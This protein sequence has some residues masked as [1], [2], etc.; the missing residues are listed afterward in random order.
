MEIPTT[1]TPSF[2]RSWWSL[3]SVGIISRHGLHQVAQKSTNVARASVHSTANGRVLS[4]VEVADVP[5]VRVRVELYE[6]DRDALKDV[7]PRLAAAISDFDAAGVARSPLTAQFQGTPTGNPDAP[8][9]G[10]LGTGPTSD[11]DVQNVL[12]FLDGTFADEVQLSTGRL[13]LSATLRFLESE[14]LARSLSRPSLT[15]LSGE[16]AQ[17]LVGGEIPIRQNAVSEASGGVITTSVV[18]EEFGIGLAVRPL[19]GRDGR[20]TLDL[21]PEITEPDFDLTADVVAATG[22]AQETIGFRTRTL[23]TSARLDD[24]QALLV[25]GLQTRSHEGT[26]SGLPVLGDAPIIGWL[27]RETAEQQ[28]R[29]ELVLV[30]TPVVLREPEARALLWHHGAPLDALLDTLPPPPEPEPEGGAADAATAPE[31]TPAVEAGS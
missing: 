31:D 6:V 14:G 3:E 19:V 18:T 5:Q 25:G 26:K 30:V 22:S 4:F 16:S 11:V 9:S 17:F 10:G 7:R 21:Q 15:V 23:R 2:A 20:V 27:F 29:T 13:A 1:R 28:R 8:F 12:N 24:G